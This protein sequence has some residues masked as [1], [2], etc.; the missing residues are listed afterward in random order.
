M[1]V[2]RMVPLCAALALCLFTASVH[3][4]AL[5]TQTTA[6]RLGLTRAWFAQIGA[7]RSTGPIGFMNCDRGMLYVQTT[8][9]SVTSIDAETGRRLWTSQIGSPNHTSSEPDGND[10]ILAVVSGSTLYVLD[11]HTGAL[12]WQRLLNGTPGAGPG[13]SA[14]YVFVPMVNGFVQG[15]NIEK[16]GKGEPWNYKSAGRVLV[17]PTATG[18]D[19]VWTTEK[20]YMYLADGE[21]GGIR[22]R[23]ETRDAIQA[24]PA[25]WTPRVFACS[26]DGNVYAVDEPS[27]KVVWKFTVGDAIYQQPVALEE[28][29]FVVSEQSGMYCLASKD[30]A[31]LWHAPRIA[32]FVSL[33]PSRVYATDDLGRLTVL[34]AETGARLGSLPLQ[35]VSIKLVNRSTDRIYLASE[36]GMVQCLRETLS[37]APVKHDP[38]VLEEVKDIKAKAKKPGSKPKGDAAD[39]DASAEEMPAED[40]P[41]EE[42]DAPAVDDAA[43]PAEP[44]AED[45]EDP[46]K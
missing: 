42:S 7:A 29:V 13:V 30:G 24:R 45:S 36:S 23:L 9:G 25:Y 38:P 11:R 3:A 21:G 10:K 16:L 1:R 46:F 43:K 8:R 6:A 15:Y 44:A 41:A 33:S 19:V 32:Q 40:M 12:L 26:T 34:D 2:C 37:K 28:K 39:A 5:L 20:G 18:N 22:Y 14:S 27:G 17:P 31:E 4:E 35:G